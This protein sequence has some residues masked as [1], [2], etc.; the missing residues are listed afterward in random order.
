M[1]R[2]LERRPNDN[3][4]RINPSVEH[5]AHV[6]RQLHLARLGRAERAFQFVRGPFDLWEIRRA[7]RAFQTMGLAENLFEQRG[8][9]CARR[10]LLQRQQRA[11]HRLDVLRGFHL[12]SG[13]QLAHDVVV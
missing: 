3:R 13:F 2:L 5:I 8:P 7:R 12:K 11:V 10:I 9:F 4:H 1:R 6:T